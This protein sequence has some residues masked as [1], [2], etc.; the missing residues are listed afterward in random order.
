MLAPFR[1]EFH[2]AG[3]ASPAVVAAY[4]IE[5][6]N[7]PRIVP[8][9]RLGR[10][11]AVVG[12]GTSL[13]Q[14]LDELRAFDGDILAVNHTALWLAQQGIA[15]T[16]LAVDSALD[17]LAKHDLIDGALLGSCCNPKLFDLM[18][19]QCFDLSEDHPGGII[20]G[21]T[22]AAR[23]PALAI[24]LGYRQVLFYGC[25]SSFGAQSHVDRDWQP[26]EQLIIQAGGQHYTTTPDYYLQAQDLAALI[27][28]MP[29]IFICRSGGLLAA[30]IE[31]P[32]SWEVIAVSDAIKSAVDAVN[33][34]E[35]NFGERWSGGPC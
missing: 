20:G 4:V 7:R 8:S 2:A 15:C 12:G 9:S 19:A 31:H 24:R 27:R 35:S 16:A 22:T 6:A 3:N 29:Q 14:N 34:G 10:R 23:A 32:D 25:D 33:P 26:L 30:M 17:N 5:N 1:L 11:V 18:P 21:T 28:L 13:A